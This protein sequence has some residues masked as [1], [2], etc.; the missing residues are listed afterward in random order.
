MSG[1]PALVVLAFIL[2]LPD[3]AAGQ[4]PYRNPDLP[5]EERVQDLLDRMTM[6]E[7]FW[8]LFMIPGDLSD[9]DADRYR[10]GIFGFQI[11]TVARE[12]DAAGQ[13]LEY[14]SSGSARQAAE[15]INDI[16]RYFVRETR[17]GIPIIPFDEGLHGL[18]REGATAFPQAIGLAATWDTTLVASVARSIASEMRSRGIRQVLS[19]VLNLAR[20]VRWGRTEETYGED[21]YL[22]STMGLA[23]V[24]AFEQAGV[25]ATPK[26]FVANVGAGGRDSYPI[27]FSERHLEDVYFPAFRTA[28]EEAGAR[29]VMMAY[30]SVDGVPATASPWLMRDIL[31]R[32]WGFDGFIISDASGTGG[33]VVPHDTATD[34]ADAGAKAITAGLDVIFQTSYDHNELFLP[35]FEQGLIDPA[36]IDEAVARVLR[37]KFELGLFEDPYIDPLAA[38][39]MNGHPDHRALAL[40]AARASIVLLRNEQ[41]VLPLDPAIGSLAVIGKDAA[42]VR[43]GGYSGPGNDPVSILDGLRQQLGDERVQYAAGPGRTSTEYVP[44]PT[45]YLFEPGS[46][47]D[48]G[49]T[50]EYFDNPWLDG[51]P[52]VRRTD[53]QIDFGWTLYSPDPSLPFDW[54]SAR[55]QGGLM[56]PSPGTYR[57]G[58]E[59]N[60]G[61]RLYLDDSLLV[62]NWAKRSYGAV[63]KDVELTAGVHD[64]RIE[65]FESTGNARLKLVWD[66]GVTDRSRALIA[67]GT[68]LAERSDAAIVVV[69]IEE[70]EFRDRSSLRLPGRQEELIRAVAETGK[71][72]I[73]VVVGGSAV[74]M[75]D[76][77]NE[78]DG[79]LYAW[80]PGE[81]GGEAVTDVLFGEVNP[82]GR[83]PITFPLSE[84][85]LPLTYDHRPTGRGDDYVDLSGQP[86]FPFGFGLSYTSFEY[87]DLDIEQNPSTST[88]SV[89]VRCTIRNAGDRAG[90]EVVQLYIRDELAS[91][92]RPVMELKGFGRIHLAPG[93]SRVV[94]FTL[95]Q[96]HL[97]M[98]DNNME[99]TV[100]PGAF[101]IMVGRSS[102]DIRLRGIL[103]V[104]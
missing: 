85:Q 81:A 92:V 22:T 55:W 86:L 2:V 91:T 11:S 42:H 64:V 74:T 53:S 83:L 23:F 46:E 51:P 16:Q 47:T 30:N 48:H 52:L 103:E 100:E 43:L 90:D 102:K 39:R 32:E 38:A 14:G 8:Q 19:P 31:K 78:V 59:G 75:N 18:V 99:W 89:T 13:M 66:H 72:T 61:Y 60:D 101:R 77:L 25:V 50:A 73:V 63:L 57:L 40:E 70:G 28:V 20:D 34:Y 68:A 12:A 98:L 49:L 65:Y 41:S 56:V 5:V 58:I 9:A 71:P 87:A 45:D 3:D 4:E 26:H 1:F 33:S 35:A 7:K 93:E 96:E 82:A 29:S 24:R 67:E 79:L 54:Y 44:I 62:D 10:H 17:L 36:V 104:R 21:P 69:G 6:E 27:H 15:K 88:A 97:R 95:G 94:S 76:W 84:G 80:Y 37:V